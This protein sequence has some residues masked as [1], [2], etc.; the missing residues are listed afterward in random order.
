ME[1]PQEVVEFV[2]DA[3]YG[4]DE[5]VQEALKAGVEVNGQSH[6]GSTALLMASANGHL[7]IVRCLLE[8]R[9]S[10]DLA[11][12]AGNCPLHW[13]SL[14]GHL[15][16]VKALVAT[17]ANPNVCNEFGKRPFDEAFSKSYS[18]ICEALAS[19]TQFE[20]PEANDKEEEVQQESPVIVSIGNPVLEITAK[21]PQETLDKYGLQ[22]GEALSGDEQ[23]D[24]KH[25]QL[26]QELEKM[27]Q[28]KYV[29]GG[30]TQNSI[31]VA[32]WMLQEAKM[33]ADL[34]CV[35]DDAY[36][37][38]LTEVCQQEGVVTRYMVDPARTSTCAVAIVDKKRTS[39]ARPGAHEH[40][41]VSH[42]KEPENFNLL[43]SAKIVYCSGSLLPVSVESVE[44]A[45]KVTEMSKST[46][47]LNLALVQ[48]PSHRA[49]L[50]KALPYC[51]VL[52]G[53]QTE[54]RAY[55][56]A[57]GWETQDV[58]FIA[59]RLS[60]VPMATK[61]PRQV[62]ITQGAEP[63]VVA[64]RG[65][66]S[67]HEVVPLSEEQIVDSYG[68]GD[69]FVGGFLAAMARKHS[70]AAC[71]QAGSYAAATVMQHWGCTFPAK[72]EYC[73]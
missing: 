36:G 28:A 72:P 8:A 32:Q 57:A 68:A 45:S 70:I 19:V 71:C 48:M 60:L 34:G 39:V 51:D 62:V 25:D 20:E 56:E 58:D 61:P 73:L 55:A 24:M 10:A 37:R 43:K 40:Y 38:R 6:G 18:E 50:E 22:H 2:L 5:A 41:K 21:V 31:R 23:K 1:P 4:D 66:I 15:E 35:G 53:N 64:V 47:C 30:A 26:L 65:V 59:T 13:A 52:F 16:V 49:V 27:E 12:D 54:A 14:N 46:Y 69:A 42:L 67:R 3:R 44:L 9:A 7:E 63:I 33:T 11:N 29:A 17:K